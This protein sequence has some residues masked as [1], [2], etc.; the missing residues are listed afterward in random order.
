MV[1]AGIFVPHITMLYFTCDLYLKYLLFSSGIYDVKTHDLSDLFGL[2]SKNRID[3]AESIVEGCKSENCSVPFDRDRLEAI[4]R[5]EGKNFELFRYPYEQLEPLHA[6]LNV[7]VP[8]VLSLRKVCD[9]EER[10]MHNNN[11]PVLSSR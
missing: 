8:F 1:G 4:L 11:N 10:L 2:L 7:M 5:D 9:N 6:H 3:L